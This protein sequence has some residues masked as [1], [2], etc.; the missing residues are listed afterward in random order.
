MLLPTATVAGFLAMVVFE[1]EFVKAIKLGRAV[2]LEY[3]SPPPLYFKMAISCAFV[4]SEKLKKK[5]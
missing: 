1:F 4:K 3:Q 2:G 5:K